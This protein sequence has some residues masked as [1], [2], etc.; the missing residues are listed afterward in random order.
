[1]PALR[2]I[3]EEEMKKVSPM[4]DRGKVAA[5]YDQYLAS[6]LPGEWYAIEVI[7]GEKPLTVRNRMRSAA[8][9]ANLTLSWRR[10]M[11]VRVEPVPVESVE[12]APLPDL[13]PE[14]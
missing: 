5:E 3:T 13:E 12:D 10:N 2:K 8:D 4:T 9:R 14:E 11:R 1:M 6:L 7:E